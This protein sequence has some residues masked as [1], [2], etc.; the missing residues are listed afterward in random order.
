MKTGRN[1][2]DGVDGLVQIFYIPLEFDIRIVY[3]ELVDR[4]N[5]GKRG[6]IKPERVIPNLEGILIVCRGDGDLARLLDPFQ[7]FMK[8]TRKQ[9]YH[10]CLISLVGV[11]LVRIVKQCGRVTGIHRRDVDTVVRHKRD[12]YLH[13]HILQDGGKLLDTYRLRLPEQ[14]VRHNSFC[15]M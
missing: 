15:F 11:V 7:R 14:L 3:G 13:Q 10:H 12:P 2:R 8:L 6:D 9:T 4:G 1:T 5:I